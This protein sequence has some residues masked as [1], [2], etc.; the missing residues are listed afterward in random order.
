MTMIVARPV[1]KGTRRRSRDPAAV[2]VGW[3]AIALTLAIFASV[4]VA[5][6]VGSYSQKPATWDEPVH[7]TDGYASW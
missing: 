3:K 5:L 7:V 1:R 2:Q 6:A 4:Y